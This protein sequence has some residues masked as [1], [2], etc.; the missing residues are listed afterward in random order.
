MRYE[1]IREIFNSCSN[2][3]MRDIYVSTVETNDP[4]LIL[5]DYIQS[6]EDIKD[7]NELPD[8]TVIFEVVRSGLRQRYSFTPDD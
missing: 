8:G 6:R 7:K 5:A 4:E 3:Q 1:M 2:N